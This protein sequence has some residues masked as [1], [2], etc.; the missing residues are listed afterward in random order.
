M[1]G[2]ICPDFSELAYHIISIRD[3]WQR[4]KGQEQQNKLEYVIGA[5][6]GI[7]LGLDHAHLMARAVIEELDSLRRAR[8]DDEIDPEG[9]EVIFIS[10]FLQEQVGEEAN[11]AMPDLVAG[12]V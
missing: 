2:R 11:P 5:M 7:S 9:I 3:F 1:S 4:A 6:I 10:A 8:T 12:G